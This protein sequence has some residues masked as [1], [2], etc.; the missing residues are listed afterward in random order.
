MEMIWTTGKT[1]VSSQLSNLYANERR[2][3]CIILLWEKILI[4]SFSLLFRQQ[5]TA[6]SWSWE[7]KSAGVQR[8]YRPQLVEFFELK[9]WRYLT[10]HL[11]QG[12]SLEWHTLISQPCLWHF[13]KF[14]KTECV[15]QRRERWDTTRNKH[16]YKKRWNNSETRHNEREKRNENNRR[17]RSSTGRMIAALQSVDEDFFTSVVSWKKRVVGWEERK[18][19]K[20]ATREMEGGREEVE[21]KNF[22]A[23]LILIGN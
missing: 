2:R 9:C 22:R 17:R 5:A 12:W 19:Y 10:S 21:N 6:V 1:T 14:I 23:S 15:R 3:V 18:H 11:G 13:E 7:I 20:K 4:K 8:R 16:I